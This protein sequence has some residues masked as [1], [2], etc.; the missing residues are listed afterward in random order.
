M[1]LG[2]WGLDATGPGAH[3]YVD[4]VQKLVLNQL[5]IGG[6]YWSSDPGSWSPWQKDG[7]PADISKVLE[8]AYPRAIA[9]TPVSIDYEKA[10][11]ELTVSW[12]D[13]PGVTG[14]TDVYL[15]ASDFPD[16]AAIE[17]NTDYSSTWNPKTRI[18]S[19]TVPQLVGVH[20]MVLTPD[21]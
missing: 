4:Q 16:G 19:V 2:A 8:T 17:L 1:L 10:T 18:L 11:L 6:A 3:L 9:G 14:S 21:S 13:K 12:T 7:K 15:P 5:M 20:T